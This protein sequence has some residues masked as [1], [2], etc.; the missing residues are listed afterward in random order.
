MSHSSF[1]FFPTFMRMNELMN[2]LFIHTFTFTARNEEEMTTIPASLFGRSNASSRNNKF[3]WNTYAK[4]KLYVCY[5]IQTKRCEKKFTDFILTM[6]RLQ[7][8]E[9][10]LNVKF[11]FGRR[12]RENFCRREWFFDLSTSPSTSVNKMSEN[13]DIYHNRWWI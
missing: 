7:T 12:R 6:L 2:G 5:A 13:Y 4:R 8:E 10:K 11:I 1:K 3:D 9:S